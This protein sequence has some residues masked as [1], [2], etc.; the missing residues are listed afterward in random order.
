MIKIYSSFIYDF[1]QVLAKIVIIN[2]L[3]ILY[4]IF[5]CLHPRIFT[6]F[7]IFLLHI[8]D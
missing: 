5:S 2:D 6:I 3:V 4:L 7:F 1:F 8:S